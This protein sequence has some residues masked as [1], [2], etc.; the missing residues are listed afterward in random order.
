MLPQVLDPRALLAPGAA[1]LVPAVVPVGTQ[2][3]A[4]PAYA[5]PLTR[6]GAGTAIWPLPYPLA[7]AGAAGKRVA[8]ALC[9][10]QALAAAVQEEPA[11]PA[12][13]RL[14]GAKGAVSAV[15]SLGLPGR[16]APREGHTLRFPPSSV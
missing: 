5:Q 14:H 15:D 7:V 4:P 3:A 6:L 8:A 10:V 13:K 12:G 11:T 2:V 16:A 9:P 1:T